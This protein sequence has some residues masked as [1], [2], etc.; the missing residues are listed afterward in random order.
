MIEYLNLYIL[1]IIL[2][3]YRNSLPGLADIKTHTNLAC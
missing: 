1:F 2:E 3:D